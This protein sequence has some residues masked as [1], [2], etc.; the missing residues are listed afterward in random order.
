MADNSSAIRAQGQQIQ[1][2]GKQ[3]Q[4][5]NQLAL[6]ALRR[7]AQNEQKLVELG[8]HVSHLVRQ[9]IGEI[10][11]F[12]LSYRIGLASNPLFSTVLGFETEQPSWI[13]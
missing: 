11:S 2:Q 4:S 1:A 9:K 5:T 8:N 3:I 10:A 6:T 7:G 12:A 13:V